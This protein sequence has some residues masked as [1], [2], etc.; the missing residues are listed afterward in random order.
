MSTDTIARASLTDQF[1]AERRGQVADIRDLMSDEGQARYITEQRER[2]D[3]Q[4]AAG[5]MKA[6]G[7][8][9]YQST[10][11]W[12]AGEVWTVRSVGGQQLVIPE[13]GLDTS[14]GRAA[15]FTAGPQPPWHDLGVWV[16]GGITDVDQAM[17]FGG[18][19]FVVK[20]RSLPSYVAKGTK[21]DLT[22][23]LGKVVNYRDDT[24]APLGIVG[25]RRANVQVVESFRF[26]Q[27]LIDDGEATIESVG[28]LGA[29]ERVFVC[30]K[31]PVDLVVDPGGLDDR[32]Q[33]FVAVRDDFSGT[34]SYEVLTTPWRIECGNT[35]RFAARDAA[36]R[37]RT[38][39]TSGI[40]GRMD[41]A[42][43]TLGLA[44]KNR[45]A[46]AEE[47]TLLARTAVSQGEAEKIMGEY[48]TV[49]A[50]GPKGQTKDNPAGRVFGGR[51]RD[52]EDDMR[53][54]RTKRANERKE[55]A[56]KA[57]WDE[58]SGKVGESLFAVQETIT[59][60]WDWDRVVEGKDPAS[61]YAARARQAFEGEHDEAKGK[62]HKGLLVRVNARG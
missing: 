11:G 7:G 10:Q 18:V 57:R 25:K 54:D 53:S 5:T 39:H 56:L 27:Q 42:R 26:L 62:A 58:E 46:L 33:Y 47:N 20:Q 28:A 16:P 59:G 49:I 48:F 60:W 15:L 21:F 50:D 3:A 38:R 13:H 35:D 44:V 41:Q 4:V 17:R 40:A 2:F 45:D 36:A 30:V 51:L 6:L 29:G 43:Q 55:A 23:L 19:S 32:T 52:A 61:Q 8:G 22:E 9:R 12:D 31:L 14:T 34:A 1:T 24:G 37:W